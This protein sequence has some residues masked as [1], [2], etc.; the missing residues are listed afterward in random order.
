MPNFLS[1]PCHICWTELVEKVPPR[2]SEVSADRSRILFGNCWSLKHQKSVTLTS[3]TLLIVGRWCSWRTTYYFVFRVGF[4]SPKSCPIFFAINLFL[5]FRTLWQFTL[6]LPK[7]Q[8]K[9]VCKFTYKIA[10]KASF[11]F[12]FFY[13]TPIKAS[14]RGEK[15]IEY[16]SWIH[17]SLW[18]IV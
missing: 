6:L 16:L 17:V 15:L 4:I 5:T 9:I 11:F 8:L 10:I 18:L 13:P 3:T 1:F 2:T 14:L 7:Y 12:F